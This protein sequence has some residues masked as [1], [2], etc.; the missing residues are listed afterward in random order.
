[1]DF[2][3]YWTLIGGDMHFADRREAAKRV[4]DAHPE[5]HF[6]IITWLRAHGKYPDRNPYFFILDF[7]NKRTRTM[8]FEQYYAKFGTT[9]ER[10]GW[11]MVKPKK[12]GDPPV[13]YVK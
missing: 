1:M 4:W 10:D 5:K 8:T 13:H 11:K 7:Q 2:N 12:A 6:A 3:I 9:E